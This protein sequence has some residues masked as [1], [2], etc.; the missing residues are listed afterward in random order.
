[1]TLKATERKTVATLDLPERAM[2]NPIRTVDEQVR[3]IK[4]RRSTRV[5]IDFPVTIF[6]Q[7]L[8]GKI[9]VEKTK[10]MT[11]SAHG[12]QVRLEKDID[13]QKPA[14][15][16][17]TKTGTEVQCRI[18]YRKEIPKRGFEVGIEFV[19]SYV[20]FWGMNFPPED[21]NPADRKKVCIA[22]R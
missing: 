13:R 5:V 6:G 20:K 8:D 1:M 4:N 10:T 11:V 18:V 22:P 17:N 14:L 21:W 19:D 12:A 9:F 16:V 7:D 2:A 3:Q 15:L